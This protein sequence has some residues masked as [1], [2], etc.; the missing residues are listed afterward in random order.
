[1]RWL[2]YRRPLAGVFEFGLFVKGK[3]ESNINCAGPEAS[4][5]KSEKRLLI[6]AVV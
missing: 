5:T 3:S 1:M 2:M 6:A 4:G